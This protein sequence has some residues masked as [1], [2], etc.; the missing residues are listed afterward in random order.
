GSITS[1]TY[2]GFDML[3]R[4]ERASAPGAAPEVHEYEY[5]GLGRRTVARSPGGERRFYWDGDR[6]AAEVFPDGRL[7]VYMY[8]SRSGLV[9]IAFTEYAGA[10][11]APESGVSYFVYSDPVGVPLHIE[12]EKGQIV[13]WAT[14]VDPYGLVDVHLGNE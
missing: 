9:P 11:A 14:R 2:D 12:D 10:D 4:I 8:P 1:Y 13:W 7:R 5:D 3:T 6:L